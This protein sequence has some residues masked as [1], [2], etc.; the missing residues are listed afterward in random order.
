MKIS[1]RESPLKLPD[2]FLTIVLKLAPRLLI[3]I[4]LLDGSCDSAANRNSQIEILN[5]SFTLPDDLKDCLVR[6]VYRTVWDH[7]VDRRSGG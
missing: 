5:R 4:M 7:Q 6:T 1:S 3:T 2:E